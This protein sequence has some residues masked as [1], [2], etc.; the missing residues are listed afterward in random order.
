MKIGKRSDID[1]HQIHGPVCGVTYQGFQW[2]DV[3]AA[4]MWALPYPR[5]VWFATKKIAA[6]AYSTRAKTLNDE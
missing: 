4:P 1:R 3:E 2:N 5:L 6:Y